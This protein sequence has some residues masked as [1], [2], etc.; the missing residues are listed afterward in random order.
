MSALTKKQKNGFKRIPKSIW[1]SEQQLSLL[2]VDRPTLLALQTKG[3]L[4][5]QIKS[6]EKKYCINSIFQK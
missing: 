3:A 5:M 4:Q 1:H 6:G 2:G